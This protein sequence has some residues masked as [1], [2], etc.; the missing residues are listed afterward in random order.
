MSQRIL[1]TN[2]IFENNELL[3]QTDS[4]VGDMKATGQMLVDSDHISFIYIVEKE[5]SYQYVS[6]PEKIWDVIREGLLAGVDASL[7]NNGNKLSLIGFREEMDY[8]VTNI[9]GNS[10]YGD[11]MVAK[12]EQVFSA[13]SA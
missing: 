3:L 6:I 2:A 13:P 5:D 1:I 10:N 4:D 9:T 7:S 11:E 12:V 8:L